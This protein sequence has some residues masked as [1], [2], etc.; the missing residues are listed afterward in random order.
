MVVFLAREAPM[1]EDVI[2]DLGQLGEGAHTAD[3]AA[4][5]PGVFDKVSDK[6]EQAGGVSEVAIREWTVTERTV[7]EAAD[8]ARSLTLVGGL[9][10]VCEAIDRIGLRERS[11]W[12]AVLGCG[13]AA[14]GH[15]PPW[16]DKRM[17]ND[18]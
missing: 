16:V 11:A 3:G 9:G 13:L 15:V 5:L 18:G 12:V 7:V 6:I 2:L 10:V 8:E 14:V 17:K 1:E 4:K